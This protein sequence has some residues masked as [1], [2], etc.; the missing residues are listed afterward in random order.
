MRSWF[1]SLA[2]VGAMTAVA[3]AQTLGPPPPVGGCGQS[4]SLFW[5]DGSAETSWTVNSPTHHG[6]AFNVDFDELAG[7]MT[8]TGIALGTWQANS[9]TAPPVAIGVRYVALCPDN[10]AVDSLGRTP[11]IKNP[12][13]I[14]GSFKGGG[15]GGTPL[16]GG[17]GVS[18]GFCPGMVVY[19]VPDVTVATSG[20][21]HTVMS[22]M[23]Q[24]SSTFICSDINTQSGKSGFTT[25]KYQTPAT[26][27]PSGSLQMRIVG[28][29]PT[30]TGSAYMTINNGASNVSVSQTAT[31]WATLW[32]TAAVQPTL[33]LQGVF[34]TGFPFIAVPNLILQTGLENFSPIS[35]LTQGTLCGPIGP[36]C[37][38]LITFGFGAFYIDN[39]DLKPNG[40]GKIKQTNTV[41]VT[42]T[43]DPAGC[44]PCLCFGQVD[45]GGMDSTIWKVLSPAGPNDYF[46]NKL[47]HFDP[48][49]S[50][51]CVVP[52]TVTS[53]QVASWDFCGT[54]N[55]WASVG[56]YPA[57]TSLGPTTPDV[58]NPVAL[59]TTLAVAPNAADWAYPA[60]L[61]DF[62]DVNSSTNTTLANA[63][64][65]HVAVQ[66]APG[67][68]CLWV[69]SDNAGTDDDGTSL[70]SCTKVPGSVTFFTTNGFTTAGTVIFQTLLMRVDWF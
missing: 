20:G 21:V 41:T 51:P 31:V 63:T 69:G 56:L 2:V 11:D 54:T 6:D 36:P 14:L 29:V 10:L 43:S 47:N 34:I 32:S 12:L 15:P 9:P 13:S 18:A 5:D 40:N 53:I 58:S 68:S 50:A 39:A 4:Q 65:L 35:D 3:T 23:T 52:A 42:L 7:N 70:G 64:T 16:T 37:P 24:D 46:T 25:S 38:P 61:Y 57:S 62:P 19:D 49:T 30:G 44:N 17:P 67:D 59:A 1:A 33:Y 48:N 45:D 60:T 55:S 66:W 8:V 27:L 26:A 28:V 22:F